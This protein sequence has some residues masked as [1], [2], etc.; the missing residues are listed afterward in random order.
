[1]RLNALACTT[2]ASDRPI[3]LIRSDPEWRAALD[4]SF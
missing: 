2:S 3:G 1:V 4:G